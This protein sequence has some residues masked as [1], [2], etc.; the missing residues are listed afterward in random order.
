MTEVTKPKKLTKAEQ[1]KRAQTAALKAHLEMST[2]GLG[3]LTHFC[4]KAC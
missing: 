3:G 4:P 2:N 1:E